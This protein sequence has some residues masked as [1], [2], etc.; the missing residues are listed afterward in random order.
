M[1]KSIRYRFYSIEMPDG[2]IYATI[3]ESIS[4]VAARHNV[5]KEKVKIG[6]DFFRMPNI[7]Q[8]YVHNGQEQA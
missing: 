2:N 8:Y 6:V 1:T 4:A 7:S 5:S 3:G